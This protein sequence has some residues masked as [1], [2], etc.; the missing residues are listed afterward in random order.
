MLACPH[1]NR[2]CI[3]RG[4]FFLASRLIPK[5]CPNCGGLVGIE[6]PF[7]GSFVAAV[8][9]LLIGSAAL[10]AHARPLSTVFLLLVGWCALTVVLSPLAPLAAISSAQ[11]ISARRFI[12]VLAAVFLGV[13][14]LAW[15]YA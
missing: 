2:E 11:V 7:S 13:A 4:E 1:C 15:L 9:F 10:L 14:F 12:K 6:G 8:E 5:Q 3:A